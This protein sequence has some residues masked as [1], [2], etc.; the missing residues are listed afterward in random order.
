MT[1][2]I[3]GLSS[4]SAALPQPGHVGF[5]SDDRGAVLLL[6]TS[7][8]WGFGI[9]SGKPAIVPGWSRL[10]S[11]WENDISMGVRAAVPRFSTG[12]VGCI[13][14][15]SLCLWGCASGDVPLDDDKTGGITR[16]AAGS[17]L[18]SGEDLAD[19]GSDLNVVPGDTV[20]RVHIPGTTRATAN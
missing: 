11:G 3:A 4:T 19:D 13:A 12:A 16:T 14:G 18:G 6:V 15:L 17:D 20:L 5:F 2:H 7:R 8:A 1:A 9:C 10:R